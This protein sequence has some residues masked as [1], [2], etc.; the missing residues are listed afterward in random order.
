MKMRRNISLTLT[1]CIISCALALCGCGGGRGGDSIFPVYTPASLD[2]DPFDSLSPAP[3]TVTARVSLEAIDSRLVIGGMIDWG[4]GSAETALQGLDEDNFVGS[5][6]Y[7]ESGS[8]Y[9]NARILTGQASISVVNCPY[10]LRIGPP[11]RD[12]VDP[13][14]GD[15]VQILDGIVLVTFND[16][17]RLSQLEGDIADDPEVAA[18][19]AAEGAR[20]NAEWSSIAAIQVVLPYNLTVE[21]AVSEWP[22]KYPDLIYGVDPVYL[23]PLGE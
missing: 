8:Y 4:D 12:Y 7:Q 20:S 15:I 16:W 3:I 14:S 21:E 6:T 23:I 5:H 1:A 2:L 9:I 10:F 18:F 13:G 22:T 11:V 17:E 19:L